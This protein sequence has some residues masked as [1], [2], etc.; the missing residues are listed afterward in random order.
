MDGDVIVQKDLT[1]LY[2][3]DLTDFYAGVVEV[4]FTKEEM[5]EG[6]PLTKYF[7]S[8]VLLLDLIAMRRDFPLPFLMEQAELKG[9]KHHDQDVLN[10]LFYGKVRFLPPRYNSM[11][12]DSELYSS[13]EGGQE[14]IE[15]PAIVHYPGNKKPWLIGGACRSAA[16]HYWQYALA[17]PYASEIIRA[18]RENCQHSVRNY[19]ARL[20][21][22]LRYQ[23]C[24][25]V[26]GARKKRYYQTKM[27]RLRRELQAIRQVKRFGKADIPWQD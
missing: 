9:T 18:Y 3:N 20:F 7:N 26:F 16:K 17:C 21:T 5:L 1:E 6:L 24:A 13:V 19:P 2:N 22:Y 15:R 12:Q 4:T 8:G 14:A 27:A 23:L 10:S 25:A 11:W